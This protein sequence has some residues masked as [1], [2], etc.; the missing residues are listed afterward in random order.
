MA[1]ALDIADAVAAELAAGEFSQP[2]TPQRKVLPAVE[3]TALKD[4]HV[5]V[6]PKAMDI[7]TASRIASQFDV[8]IDIGVQKKLSGEIEAEV[9]TLLS[10][11]EEIAGFLRGRS[12]AGAPQ[13]TWVRTANE[14]LYAPDHLAEQRVFTSVLTVTYR[15]LR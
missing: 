14:P 2:F 11:V 9:P 5:T 1:L 12:L 4:L 10:L 15:V 8:Q 6:V 13:A 7:T 3:L